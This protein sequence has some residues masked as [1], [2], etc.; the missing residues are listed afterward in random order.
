MKKKTQG[1]APSL[2]QASGRVRA[3]K[4]EFKRLRSLTK[5]AKRELK[6]A[7]KAFKKA[8]KLAAPDAAKKPA[9]KAKP[10]KATKPKPKTKTRKPVARKK[11][12]APPRALA[13]PAT[14]AMRETHGRPHARTTRRPRPTVLDDAALLANSETELG[15]ESESPTA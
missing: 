12:Q 2:Q 7:R 14:P 9:A 11:A 1:A 3:A 8:R 5:V 4:D 6:A 10:A 13:A 15:E